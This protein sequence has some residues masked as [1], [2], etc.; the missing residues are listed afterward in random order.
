MDYKLWMKLLSKSSDDPAVKAELAKIGLTKK[1][2]VAKHDT[3]VRID[4]K[5]TG[6]TLVFAD[7]AFLYKLKNRSIGDDPPVLS[8]I[9][10]LL[11]HSKEPIYKGPLPFDLNREDSQAKLLGR[12]GKPFKHNDDFFW[13][14]WMVGDLALTV[15]FTEDY[16]S[17]SLV[18][19]EIPGKE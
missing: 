3:D 7:P 2:K 18:N 16:Q 15:E 11:K 6:I 17:I 10:L 12:F 1:L 19:V 14:R 8:E 4:V 5:D 13:D 9:L